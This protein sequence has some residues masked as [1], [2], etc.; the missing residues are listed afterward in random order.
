PGELCQGDVL[1]RTANRGVHPLPRMSH[2]ASVL[3]TAGTVVAAA[4][5]QGQR[6][7]ERIENRGGADLLRVQRQLIATEAPACGANEPTSLEDLEEL[8]D[9]CDAE[10][11]AFGDLG[12]REPA[13]RLIGERR[14]DDRRVV[15]ELAD[16]QHG[17]PVWKTVLRRYGT[18]LVPMQW[19][20]LRL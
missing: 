4:L 6:T 17:R 20:S 8:A 18:I 16:P 7:F 5:R 15:G 1:E 19:F 3:D 10:A 11:R 14:E 2:T 13:F 9:R 12:R